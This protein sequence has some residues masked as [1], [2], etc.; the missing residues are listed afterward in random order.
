MVYLIQMD[1]DEF[2]L[3]DDI[4]PAYAV[5]FTIAHEAGVEA[6]AVVCKVDPQR[7]EVARRAPIRL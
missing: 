7:I 4:D 5:A 3:A 6:I 2:A 1:A